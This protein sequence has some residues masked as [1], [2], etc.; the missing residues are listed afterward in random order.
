VIK[1][2]ALNAPNCSV[3]LNQLF[4]WMACHHAILAEIIAAAFLLFPRTVRIEQL[5]PGYCSSI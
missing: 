3:S 1:G 2:F 5:W 4:R